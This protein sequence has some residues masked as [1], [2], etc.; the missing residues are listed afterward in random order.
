[1]WYKLEHFRL[2][3][4]NHHLLLFCVILNNMP[5]LLCELSPQSFELSLEVIS[6]SLSV[7]LFYKDN[8]ITK[9]YSKTKSEYKHCN[10][11]LLP[12]APPNAALTL[13]RLNIVKCDLCVEICDKSSRW[14][15]VFIISSCSGCNQICVE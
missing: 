1:M 6:C 12:S 4:K 5:V 3:D 9:S 14:V 8:A 13:L 7:A 11:C 2:S 10:M 15:A